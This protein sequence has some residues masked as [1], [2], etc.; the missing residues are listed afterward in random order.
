MRAIH[1]DWGGNITI[2]RSGI[3]NRKYIYCIKDRF[4][5]CWLSETKERL[6]QIMQLD[7]GEQLTQQIKFSTV[8]ELDGSVISNRARSELDQ[9]HDVCFKNLA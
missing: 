2:L 4:N 3:L 5:K 6:L 1:T 9:H 7:S 8:L